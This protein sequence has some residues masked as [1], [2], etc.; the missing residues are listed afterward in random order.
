M[1]MTSQDSK[2][3]YQT[4]IGLKKINIP[5]AYQGPCMFLY[6]RF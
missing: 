5:Y 4:L 2:H 3:C 1:S 6:P